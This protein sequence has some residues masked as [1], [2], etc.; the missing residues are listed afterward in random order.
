MQKGLGI[1]DSPALS[2]ASV[3]KQLRAWGIAETPTSLHY[4]PSSSGPTAS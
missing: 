4:S 1:S 2:R 3:K